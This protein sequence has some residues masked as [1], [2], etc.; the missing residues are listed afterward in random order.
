MKQTIY[1]SQFKQAFHDYGRGNNFSYDGLRAL[2][3]MLTEFEESK[4]EEMELDVIE[5]CCDYTEFKDMEELQ[6][7]YPDIE[8]IENL[9]D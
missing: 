1:F 5:L 9:Q 2:Y 4:G 7:S 8:T 6:Q 3:D